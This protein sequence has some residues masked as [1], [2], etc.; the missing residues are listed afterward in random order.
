MKVIILGV[1]RYVEDIVERVSEFG[2]LVL[3]ERDRTKLKSFFEKEEELESLKV[4]EGNATDINFWEEELKGEEEIAVISFLKE[5]ATLKVA[6]L[7][8]KA[9]EF[10]GAIVFVAR[11]KTQS[12]ELADLEVEVVSVPDML[13]AILRNVL[14]GR[15]VVRYP[16]GIGL[17]RGEVVELLITQGSPAVYMKLSELRQKN[18]RIALIYRDRNIILPRTDLRVQPGDRLLIVGEPS[19]VE[20]FVSGI[21]RGM[22]TFPRKWGNIGVLCGKTTEEFEYV[23]GRLSLKEWRESSCKDMGVEEETG[24]VVAREGM[25]DRIFEGL[26]VPSIITRGS[27]P[28]K[29]ILLSANTDAM[30]LLLPSVIEFAQLFNSKVYI[31][32]VSSIKK[33]MTPEEKELF[34]TLKSF[35]D[36]SRKV[37]KVEIEL[38]KKEGNP[39]RETLKLLKGKFNLLA[40]GYTPGRLS[41]FF[42]PYTPHLLAKKTRLSILLVPEVN[43]ER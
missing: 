18:T 33:M 9:L 11:E 29:D 37:L 32:F 16:V 42:N 34:Q 36:R 1:G 30:N 43:F 26:E 40:L 25:I 15:G 31:L 22:S 14:K 7:L 10:K 28:Y 38:I 35:V 20:L 24:L 12:R 6:K 41:S 23:R 3:V 2:Q 27:F 13:G 8:R 4:L 5:E 19:S 17:R 21:T 39:V